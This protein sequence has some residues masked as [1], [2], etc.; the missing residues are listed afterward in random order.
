MSHVQ[1]FANLCSPKCLQSPN[2]ETRKDCSKQHN[3]GTVPDEVQEVRPQSTVTGKPV[4]Q[5]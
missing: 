4:D 5:Y 2:I 3:R 1:H